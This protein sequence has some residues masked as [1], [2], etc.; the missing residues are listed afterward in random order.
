MNSSSDK[1]IDGGPL[2]RFALL[3]RRWRQIID[4][5]LRTSGL[6]DATWR[7]LF[8][9]NVL[10]DGTRQKDLAEALGVKGPSLVRLLETLLDKGLIESSADA[11]D[12]RAKLLS[13]SSTGKACARR[14]Q[15]RVQ[16]LE[17]Q[18]LAVLNEEQT[19]Q[20][21]GIIQ[22]F[23]SGLDNWDKQA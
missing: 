11:M 6:T 2:F 16:A 13:L 23:E 8:Y 15:Q 1:I 19:T 7:P 4:Q 9:L 17:Q 18:V 20:L 21:P 12:R 3:T 22:A 10:G 5:E 14:V